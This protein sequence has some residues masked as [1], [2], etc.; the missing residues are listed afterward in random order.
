MLFLRVALLALLAA[1]AAAYDM[2]QYTK[3]QGEA[4]YYGAGND[5]RG[6]CGGNGLP[7][8]P[9]GLMTVALNS[10]QY[11]GGENCGKCIEG[12]ASGD[13]AG[14]NPIPSKFFAAINNL[15]PEVREADGERERGGGSLPAPVFTHPPPTTRA[16]LTHH[17]H[18]KKNKK[19]KKNK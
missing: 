3:Y 4:T 9:G 14:G 18:D 2:P 15:C 7:T 17:C 8:G 16:L 11:G 5:N 19:N 6:A 12:T 13:G 1:L 10:P